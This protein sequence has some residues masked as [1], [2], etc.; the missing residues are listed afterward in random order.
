MRARNLKPGFFKNECLLS[1]SPLHRL[2]FAGLWCI[3]DRN[4]ILE[5]RPAKIKIEI[6]P[7]DN[8]DVDGMLD[9][10][11]TVHGFIERYEVGGNRYLVIAN[12]SKHQKPHPRELALYP[13]PEDKQEIATASR[14]KG[15]VSKAFTSSSFNPSSFNPSSFNPSSLNHKEKEESKECVATSPQKPAKTLVYPPDFELFWQEYPSYIDKRRSFGCWK[16]RQKEGITSD[17]LTACARNYAAARRGEDQRYTMHPATFL[18]P[19]RRWEEFLEAKK[20][21]GNGSPTKLHYSNKKAPEM[22]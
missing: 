11:S 16:A 6:L 8:C 9:E 2:L 20:K 21:G 3:A 18:G 4:G 17:Q 14:E 15:L 5:D 1:L 12:F 19:G 22:C 7:V 13:K 10:L